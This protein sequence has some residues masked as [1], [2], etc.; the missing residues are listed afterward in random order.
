MK[1]RIKILHVDDN[2]LDRQLVKD[3][4]CKEHDAFELIEADSRE[5]FE[6]HLDEKDFDLILSDFNILGF[7]GLQVLQMVHEKCPE[8]PV[9]IVTGTGSE[10]VAIRAM[11]MGASDYVIKSANHIRGLA[12][13]I[14]HVI[15]KTRLQHDKAEVLDSL[16]RNEKKYRLLFDSNPHPMWVYDLETLNF[17]EVNHTATLKY[18]YSR[19]QFLTMNLKDIRPDE[20]V[21]K[22]FDNVREGADEYTFSGEWRHK[23]RNGDIFLVEIISHSIDY[24]DKKARLVIANDIT[25]RK[26]IEDKLKLYTRA[27]EQSPVSINITN[28]EGALIYVNSGFTALSGYSSR[29]VIGRNPR[30]LK[31]GIHSDA[32]YKEL[33]ESVTAGNSWKGELCNKNKDGNLYW[34]QA[35]IS[36]VLDTKGR[37]THFVAI[38]EDITEIKKFT[39]DLKISKEKAEESDRL[40]TAFLANMSHEI[41]TPMNGILGFTDLLLDPD[42]SSEQKEDYIKLVHQSGQRMLNTVNDIVEISKIEAGLVN[43]IIK[44]TD[45]NERVEGLFRF[46]QPEA[47]KK[48]LKLILEMLLPAEKK[49]LNTDQNK[50]DSILSNL[51]KNA[52]KYTD[53][54]S[55]C[56]GCQQRG[57]LIEFYIRDTGIGIPKNRQNAIFDRF[58]QADI[59]DRRAFQGSGLGLAIS[60][61]YIEM[62]GGKIWV[63]S[64]EG[65]G[66]TFYFTLP[67][68]PVPEEKK[69][70]GETVLVKDKEN[71]I[72]PEVSGL[73]ILIA[74]DD[75]TSERLINIS[76]DKYA[77]E[78]LAARTGLETVEVCR[79]NPDTDLILM[80]IQMPLFNGY[81]AT[82]QIR[83]FNK[84]VVII[85]QTAFGLSG[86]REKAIESGCNEYI[87][88]PI[89]NSELLSLIQKYFK[90]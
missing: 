10:E 79:N 87:S 67:Y 47:K 48:G 55:I 9:I 60:K 26:K 43:V 41:R 19:D 36:P 27:I 4:L 17:L 84:D 33:W 24:N 56:L 31:S 44:A 1:N 62:L 72:I 6:H 18:G 89:R 64:E 69:V 40:K 3:A 54:G 13:T 14:E 38:K 57:H 88:K 12:I 68:I 15:E 66:S 34:V 58:V 80:D 63:E 70:S 8:I 25:E 7:D 16:E 46:F 35:N 2:A 53:S 42:L 76:V 37:I 51:I 86:D 5:S 85:A 75:E 29:E 74:E 28:N 49:N 52:L 78:I 71:Q 90:K 61:S 73:K 11:K 65:I 20:D 50:L 22:L 39:E 21:E 81:E 30:F 82:R 23:N 77:K 83:Q 59:S 45:L 32:F